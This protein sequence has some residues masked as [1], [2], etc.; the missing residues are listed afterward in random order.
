MFYIK[1][2]VLFN[3]MFIIMLLGMALLT[4]CLK[5]SNDYEEVDF[6]AVHPFI[7]L[8]MGV[9]G[10]LIFFGRLQHLSED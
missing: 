1:N 2:Y 6:F 5:I 8:I 10:E 9:N 7:F 3:L 4:R